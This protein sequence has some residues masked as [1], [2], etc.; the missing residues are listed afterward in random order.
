MTAKGVA[1]VLSGQGPA[2]NH[3]GEE[4]HEEDDAKDEAEEGAWVVDKG[5]HCVFGEIIQRRRRRKVV[6]IIQRVTRWGE[7]T[8]TAC[9]CRGGTVTVTGTVRGTGSKGGTFEE[10]VIVIVVAVAVVVVVWVTTYITL[11]LLLSSLWGS[12]GR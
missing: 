1:E 7:K 3:V 10:V 6:Q 4:T 5:E 8:V 2:G 12:N 11:G 9:R